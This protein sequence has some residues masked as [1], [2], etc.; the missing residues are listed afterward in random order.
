M[1][2]TLDAGMDKAHNED[3]DV[4]GMWM[5]KMRTAGT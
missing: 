3:A 1:D 2:D 4:R 5:G